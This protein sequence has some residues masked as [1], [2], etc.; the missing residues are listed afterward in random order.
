M[1]YVRGAPKD[2]AGDVPPE[3]EE[4]SVEPEPPKGRVYPQPIAIQLN[5]E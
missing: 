4:P 5:E 3:L 2:Q 1:S